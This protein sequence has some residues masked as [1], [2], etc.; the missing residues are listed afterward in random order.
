MNKEEIEMSFNNHFDT[1]I[2]NPLIDDAFEITY[3]EKIDIITE[4][5]EKIIEA[6]YLCQIFGKRK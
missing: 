1:K 6:W 4:H 2:N 5:F 3:E